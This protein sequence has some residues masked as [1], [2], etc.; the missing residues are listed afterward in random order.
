MH[1]VVEVIA[2]GFVIDSWSRG[3]ATFDK[4]T[5]K[6]PS[7]WKVEGFVARLSARP[8]GRAST[9]AVDRI[10]VV[11]EGIL[12]LLLRW[13]LAEPQIRVTVDGKPIRRSRNISRLQ[14]YEIGA[15]LA[16]NPHL[17]RTVLGLKQEALERIELLW[18]LATRLPV[19][20]L[21]RLLG[22][23]SQGSSAASARHPFDRVPPLWSAL[24]LM[25][26]GGKDLDRI[27]RILA[28]P[29]FPSVEAAHWTKEARRILSYRA[30]LARDPW[31]H[32]PVRQHLLA[33]PTNDGDRVR[34]ATVAAYAVRSMIVHGQ[35][36][37]FRDDRRL[38]AGA[39][40]AWF[41]QILERE[42]EL[43]L[44]GRRLDPI[45]VVGSTQISG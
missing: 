17:P 27:D 6:D 39:A 33:S 28:D 35:W 7:G 31:L 20:E 22:P 26:P 45:P 42:M 4:A 37:R 36:A 14:P 32:P 11:A 23:L 19:K 43:R 29:A 21:D 9:T 34:V 41:W 30:R 10:V 5:F 15:I 38:E 25:Y 8:R 40:A 44:A 1:V 13:P 3:A 18:S 16:G 12:D 24:E 2:P